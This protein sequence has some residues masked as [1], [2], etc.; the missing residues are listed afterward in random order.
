MCFSLTPTGKEKI[1]Q[2][3][4]AKLHFDGLFEKLKTCMSKG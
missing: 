2:M 3:M 4:N 1:Q